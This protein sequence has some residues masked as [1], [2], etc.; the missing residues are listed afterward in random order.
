MNVLKYNIALYTYLFLA[1]SIGWY[2]NHIG[3]SYVKKYD[4]MILL[5]IET[6]VVLC[7]AT[8][9]LAYKHYKN[10]QDIIKNLNKISVKD[11]IVFVLFALYG[12]FASFIGLEFLKYHDV[13]KIRISDFIIS[14]PI[15]AFGLYFF[16][17]NPIS[18]EKILGLIAVVIGGY[19]F[20][21]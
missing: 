10:P 4:T 13:A 18:T 6:I 12:M 5:L 20:L 15:S 14:I 1:I 16:S 2:Y 7:G 9:T 17:K 11:Y 21:R 19:F 3:K 8:I